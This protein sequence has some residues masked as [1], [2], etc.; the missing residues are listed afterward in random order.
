MSGLLHSSISEKYG[1]FL[2]KDGTFLK[3]HNKNM[4]HSLK[5]ITN[6]AHS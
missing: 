1:T 6:M 5:S 3:K 4:A 2:K